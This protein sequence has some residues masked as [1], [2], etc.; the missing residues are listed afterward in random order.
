MLTN[1]LISLPT[2]FTACLLSYLMEQRYCSRYNYE[3]YGTYG[4]VYDFRYG[5]ASFSSQKMSKPS[6]LLFPG[7]GVLSLGKAAETWSRPLTSI[8]CR[9]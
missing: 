7:T 9:D 4:T 5:Q 6:S 2:Q 1:T 3:Y 8:Y